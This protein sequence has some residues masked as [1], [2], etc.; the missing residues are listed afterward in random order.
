MRPL[1]TC[2]ARH[3]QNSAM[4]SDHIDFQSIKRAACNSLGSILRHWLPDGRRVGNEW[5]ALN[6][7]RADRR[8]GSFSVNL[9]TGKW[10]DFA[11]GD[12]GGDVVSLAAY[13]FNQTQTQAARNL[14]RMLGIDHG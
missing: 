2:A 13:L 10:A 14:A 7:R 8:P 6:P 4:K 9:N 5:V 3:R 1:S 11:T 12:C